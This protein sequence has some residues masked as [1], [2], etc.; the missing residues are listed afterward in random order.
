MLTASLVVLSMLLF[1]SSIIS[2]SMSLY[3]CRAE[4]VRAKGLRPRGPAG[5][6]LL[7]ASVGVGWGM[8][9]CHRIVITN[10]MSL[11]S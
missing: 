2:T 10:G 3:H 1:I 8:M 4:L 5:K 6:L 9:L 7:N 11:Y